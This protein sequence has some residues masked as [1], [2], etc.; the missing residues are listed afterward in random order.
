MFP[1]IDL[2]YNDIHAEKSLADLTGDP[3]NLLEINHSRDGR[4]ECCVDG[5]RVYLAPTW[6]DKK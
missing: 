3:R 5:D 4:M 1:G 6:K 2:I